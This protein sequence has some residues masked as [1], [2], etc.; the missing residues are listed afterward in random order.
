ML[1]SYSVAGCKIPSDVKAVTDFSTCDHTAMY[2]HIH[3]LKTMKILENEEA[4]GT[5]FALEMGIL[6]RTII[7]FYLNS[8]ANTSHFLTN[9]YQNWTLHIQVCSF[10]VHMSWRYTESFKPIFFI[11][12]NDKKIFMNNE[13][14]KQNVNDTVTKDRLY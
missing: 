12:V 13:H 14:I 6:F 3:F 10:L 7:F 4:G 9:L 1:T 11:L 5:L 2:R 8:I